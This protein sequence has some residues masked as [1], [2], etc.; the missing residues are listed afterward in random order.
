M[1]K[2]MSKETCAKFGEREVPASLGDCSLSWTWV[3][4][5]SGGAVTEEKR[6][7]VPLPP[8]QW[9]VL[10]SCVFSSSA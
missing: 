9:G 8:P 7:P 1:L 5:F 4:W 2:E 6:P 10:P 3:L